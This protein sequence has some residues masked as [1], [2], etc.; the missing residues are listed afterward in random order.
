[1]FFG[2][3]LLTVE[4]RQKSTEQYWEETGCGLQ[5]TVFLCVV[6]GFEAIGVIVV[7]S[8]EANAQ[9]AGFFDPVG[10]SARMSSNNV[11]A[12]TTTRVA[13]SFSS[14]APS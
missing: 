11:K 14:P 1:M 7:A 3:S 10:R 9:I 13:L 5:G 6:Y 8:V 12:I 2:L 4:M